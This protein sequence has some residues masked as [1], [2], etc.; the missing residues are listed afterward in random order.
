MYLPISLG[1]ILLDR[2]RAL[3]SRRGLTNQRRPMGVAVQAF[4]RPTRG[5]FDVLNKR[6][7]DYPCCF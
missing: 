4:Q 3:V 2:S 6:K 5:I 1:S 7:E